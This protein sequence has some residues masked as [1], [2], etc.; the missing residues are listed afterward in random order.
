MIEK[1]R[2]WKGAP[3]GIKEFAL[4]Q[5]KDSKEFD[6]R[7]PY[8]FWGT[9]PEIDPFVWINDKLTLAA[10]EIKRAEEAY[11]EEVERVEGR[12]AWIKQLK[13]SLA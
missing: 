9:P 1:V 4:S 11:K 10:R 3:E 2:A 13:E 5:L 7:E 6:C 12:N 8:R